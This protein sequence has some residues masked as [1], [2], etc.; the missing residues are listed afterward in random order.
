MWDNLDL[1]Q[2]LLTTGADVNARD[3]Q[4]RSALHAAALAERSQCL[5]ALCAAGA[6]VDAKSDEQTGGKVIALF[7]HEN[8]V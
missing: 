7:P 5:S 8:F 6:D 3:P 1:L 2:E 4:S